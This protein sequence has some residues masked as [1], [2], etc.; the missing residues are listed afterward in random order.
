MASRLVTER[1]VLR[2]WMAD[3]AEAALGVYGDRQVT[4]WLAPELDKV[5]DL[6]A[7]RLVLQRWSAEDAQ[8]MAPAGLGAGVCHGGRA[9]TR[10]VGIRA[11][12]R[13]GD[14]AGAACEYARDG[15]GA[16]DWHGMG[17]RDREISSAA[18]AGVPAKSWSPGLAWRRGVACAIRLGGYRAMSGARRPAIP[19]SARRPARCPGFQQTGQ[20]HVTA[21]SIAITSATK[22]SASPQAARCLTHVAR[23]V[24]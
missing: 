6:T 11:G 15:D 16:P 19:R 5:T 14:G 10:T 8:M 3:D 24:Q 22:L 18:L 21:H 7:M 1:L 13:A 23:L 4:R 9:G 12:H 17:W 2:G 20:L